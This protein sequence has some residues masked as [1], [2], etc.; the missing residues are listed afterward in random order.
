MPPLDCSKGFKL[1]LYL[2]TSG[3]EHT[4]T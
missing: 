1:Q 4:S 2:F 3:P